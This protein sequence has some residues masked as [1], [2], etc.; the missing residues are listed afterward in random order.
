MISANKKIFVMMLLLFAAS[1]VSAGWTGIDDYDIADI[2]TDVGTVNNNLTGK[3]PDTVLYDLTQQRKDW[4]PYKANT[5]LLADGVQDILDSLPA[6]RSEFLDFIDADSVGS[7][8]KC[9]YLSDCYA[10]RNDLVELFSGLNKLKSKFPV[11][12]KA[13]LADTSIAQKVIFETPPI[14]L[15]GMYKVMNRQ[16]VWKNLPLI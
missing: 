5:P 16:P 2:F 1:Q 7:P 6:L 13:G 14:I 3:I 9:N 4:L 12:E 10:F 11:F 8:D 15:F